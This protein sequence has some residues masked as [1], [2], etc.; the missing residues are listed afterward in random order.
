MDKKRSSAAPYIVMLVLAAAIAALLLYIL[1]YR[2]RLNQTVFFEESDETLYNPLIGYA[3]AADETG[4]HEDSN[5]VYIGLTWAEWEPVQGQYDIAG[6]EEKYHIKEW[7]AQNKHAVLRFLCDIPGEAQH[8]DIPQW[9]YERTGDG[10]FYDTS[11]GSGYCP[12]YGNDFFRE[13]HGM[14][15]EALAEYFNEDDFLAYVELGSL[16]HWG[17][18]HTNTDEGVLSLPDV[19]TCW[20]YVLDYSDNFHNAR[21]LMRRNYVMVA[22][23][24]LG[25]YND[26]TGH[27]GDT[28]EWLGWIESGGSYEVENGEL[29][30]EP[31]P[32]FWKEAPVGGE[33]TS[34]LSME[35]MLDT[36]LGTTL[37]L[38]ERSH[39]SF[40]GPHTPKDEETEL[41]GADAV[42]EL[43]G[44]RF[45]ISSLQ[46]QFSF[47]DDA[48]DVYMTWENTGIAPLYWDWP[49]MMYV[50]DLE[51]NLRYWESVN[52]RLS[53][54]MPG[55]Q[56]VTE[57]QIP[58]TDLL[59]QGYSIGVGIV[60]P[61]E[62]ETI[63]LAMDC[64]KT[65][66]GIHLIY[67]YE[68]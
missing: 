30:L 67:T 33:F 59:R 21:L 28:E 6:L 66:E 61:N 27:K 50:Y 7:K 34:S 2:Y 36:E 39:M 11:Y 3:V 35:E 54:L 32:D 15:I 10:E 24:G 49:V 38:I 58:F 13:R 22:D 37:D 40:I 52:I 17:E 55:E 26:M 48:L 9:L 63:A 20:E 65:D 41:P 43:L 29:T 46:T 4:G 42:Q 12:D 19:N 31:V 8:M 57:N 51:G 56:I 60:S 62:Q 23:G 47:A 16:G 18:W 1:P 14:A 45:Y 5:L 44:Y 64:E 68:N 53:E 25:L